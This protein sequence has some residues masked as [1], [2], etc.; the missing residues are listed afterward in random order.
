MPISDTAW[1]DLQAAIAALLT[2]R[3]KD[4][5]SEIPR[6]RL[7]SLAALVQIGTV[8]SLWDG[9]APMLCDP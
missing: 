3:K 5:P 1:L 8:R 6:T 9:F 2:L 7:G 4:E